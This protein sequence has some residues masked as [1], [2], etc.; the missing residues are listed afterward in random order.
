MHQVPFGKLNAQRLSHFSFA[1]LSFLCAAA[2]KAVFVPSLRSQ[3]HSGM[4]QH[5]HI[6]VSRANRGDLPDTS[7]PRAICVYLTPQC[8]RGSVTMEGANKYWWK[9]DFSVWFQ[10][11]GPWWHNQLLWHTS[12]YYPEHWMTP[13]S[14]VIFIPQN[15]YWRRTVKQSLPLSISMLNV[16]NPT[17]KTSPQHVIALQSCKLLSFHDVS[18][19]WGLFLY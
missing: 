17:R 14:Y 2:T 16:C 3:P 1:H 10:R 12:Y 8:S 5:L 4:W 18:F 11:G 6:S 13:F 9:S 15:F 7:A 19:I